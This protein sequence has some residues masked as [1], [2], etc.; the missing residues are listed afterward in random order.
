VF[1]Q[2]G[3]KWRL[4]TVYLGSVDESRVT[5]A[6]PGVNVKQLEMNNKNYFKEIL[7]EK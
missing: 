7:I 6:N 2:A 5:N 1:Y 3:Q 4:I